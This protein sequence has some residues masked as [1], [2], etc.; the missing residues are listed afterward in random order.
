MQY[1]ISDHV[2]IGV[3]TDIITPFISDGFDNG[4]LCAATI[5][6]GYEVIPKLYLA[7]SVIA[8]NIPFDVTESSASGGVLGL[9]L[10]TYGTRNSNATFGVSYGY[11]NWEPAGAPSYT[12]SGMTRVSRRL[13]LV[14]ENW[15]VAYRKRMYIY[16]STMPQLV[17]YDQLSHQF[18]GSYGLRF[19][20]EKMS[21]D[22]GFINNEDIV[23]G[24]VIGVPYVDFVVKF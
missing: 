9:G 20:G 23:K 13:A 16:D 5:K 11:K 14:T 18:I 24:L 1:G 2:S 17:M 12:L 6:V 8:Y 22:F 4:P 21:V 10:I 19:M 3:G 7:G 15:L